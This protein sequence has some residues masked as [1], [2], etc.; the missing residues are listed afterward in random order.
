MLGISK[1]AVHQ[2]MNRELTKLEEL[3]Y[4]IPIVDQVREDHPRMAL[5][6]LYTLIKP[7]TMGRDAFEHR[8][9]ELGYSV[10]IRRNYKRT[11]NS[12]GVV[13]FDNLIRDY[14]LTGVNQ[15]WVSDITYYQMKDHF[16]YL[17]FITDLYS[18]RILGA[19]CSSTLRT[20]K[21]TI[22]ALKE[23]FETRKTTRL[24]GTIIHSDGGGQYYSK[25][26]LSL[27]KDAQMV[28]S[29]GKAAYENPHAERLN[30]IIKNNYII[31]Y[32]PTTSLRLKRAL[33]KAIHKYNSEK[34]HSALGGLN[35]ESFE[36]V[37]H[38]STGI[39]KEKRSKKE[40]YNNSNNSILKT[41]N[42]I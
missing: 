40:N 19:S 4:L 41:V 13:R 20:E 10:S 26:F 15:V 7:K 16:H 1:Q 30:G 29:M 5:R 31:P 17:T 38:K 23:A 28:N 25:E 21:T 42:V 11:T 35:P 14:E 36:Q 39:N 37:I 2:K 22:P 33:K 24:P 34:P 6:D 32:G 27:T 18:R 12:T 9:A 8:F 3:N